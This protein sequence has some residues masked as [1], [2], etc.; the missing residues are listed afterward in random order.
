MVR[1]K[2]HIFLTER[3]TNQS[4]VKAGFSEPTP[5][6]ERGVDYRITDTL[7]ITE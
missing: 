7:G 2:S 3:S 6:H 4:E 5:P 1:H